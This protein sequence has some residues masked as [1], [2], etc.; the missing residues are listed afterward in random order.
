MKKIATTLVVLGA[1]CA[2]MMTGC[3]NND[4]AG[5][6]TTSSA[7]APTTSGAAAP[8]TS[9]PATSG[10][11]AT[12]AGGASSAVLNPG[13]PA[14]STIGISL[15]QKTS[16]NWVLAEG[17]FNDGLKAA[18]Y[19]GIVNFA[20]GGVS[21]QQNQISAQIQNGAKVIVIGAIDGSQLTSQVEAAKAAGITVIAYDRLIMNTDAVDMYVAYDNCKV[22]TLQGQALLDGLAA[23]KGPS[24]WNIELIAGSPDDANSTPF[25]Q[26]AMDVLQPKIDDG[27]LVVKSGQTSQSQVATAGWLASNVQTRFDAL[28][29]ANY[30]GG[31]KLDGV[32]SP[33]DT[34]ARAAI[35]SVE[36]AG[37]PDPVITGQDSEVQSIDYI[38]EGKQYSTINKDTNNLV[39]KVIDIINTM[40]K[41]GTVDFNDTT[42]Y[43]NGVKVVPAYLLDPVI[44]TKA[45]L[46]TAYDPATAAGQEAAKQT[47]CQ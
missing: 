29:A 17:L 26:C 30:Q 47:M 45:N 35:T 22:G 14:G 23:Q 31:T 12:T 11:A 33:N 15:P 16:E 38:A 13:F 32:L 27:T 43:N 10:A 18:G 24:P 25:F 42:S 6:G 9:A 20:D 34:L 37:M 1:G 19:N 3:A 44:V 21:D 4:R 8:A 39:A 46:C 36:S 41:G 28:L 7:P 40:Q 5:S 2:L